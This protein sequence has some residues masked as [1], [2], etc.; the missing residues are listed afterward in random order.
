MLINLLLKELRNTSFFSK[1]RKGNALSAILGLI[2][3]LAFVVIE[4]VV[5]SLLNV[6]LAKYKKTYLGRLF[7]WI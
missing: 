5:F 2:T 1:V 3:T 4:V 7:L 6:K